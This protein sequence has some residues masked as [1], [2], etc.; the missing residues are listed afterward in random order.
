MIT[1]QS[2][3]VKHNAYKTITTHTAKNTIAAN[4]VFKEFYLNRKKS[5]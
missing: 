5:L 1:Y 2:G 4:K 3:A